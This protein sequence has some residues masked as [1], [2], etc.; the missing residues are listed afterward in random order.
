M[1]T[2][3][4][5]VESLQDQ[6]V[7]NALIYSQKSYC[8]YVHRFPNLACQCHANKASFGRKFALKW[9]MWMLLLKTDAENSQIRYKNTSGVSGENFLMVIS[10]VSKFRNIPNY[11]TLSKSFWV[12][13]Y[14]CSRNYY[15]C[16][17]KCFQKRG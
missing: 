16:L 17:D 8:Q 4:V 3:F 10:S 11:F 5:L 15:K 9:K 2:I 7:T 6:F 13:E 12:A 14:V 1:H